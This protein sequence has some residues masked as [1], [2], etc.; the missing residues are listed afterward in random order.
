MA[1]VHDILLLWFD[2]LGLCLPPLFLVS[3]FLFFFDIQRY[4]LLTDR[5]IV[6]HRV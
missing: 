1:G 5:R 3:P 2:I 6:L 4:S